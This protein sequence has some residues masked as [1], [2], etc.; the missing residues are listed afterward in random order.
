MQMTL[1]TATAAHDFHAHRGAGAGERPADPL[2]RRA[3]VRPPSRGAPRRCIALARLAA[4]QRGLRVYGQGVTTDAA[5]HL[6]VRG[7][8]PLRRRRGVGRGDRRHARGA[9]GEARRSRAPARAL[10]GYESGIVTVPIPDITILECFTPET[11]P[12]REPAPSA[13]SPSATGK[14]PVDAMLDIAVADDLRTVFYAEPANVDR[15]ALREIIDYAVD[16]PRRVRRR[17]AHEV[18][19][20]R[21]LSDRVPL[22]RSC[23]RRRCAR[24]STR[25]GGSRRCPRTAPASAT[26]ARSS[27]ARPPTSSSTTSRSSSACRPRSRTTSRAASGGASSARAATAASW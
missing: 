5:L 26:A 21:P 25:T 1:A 14:H 24:S 18:L 6:H 2:Q 12:L 23:A 27:R 15:E 13:R 4:A 16:P 11:K 3:V 22:A 9:Q 10:R 7:L 8:E 19:H 17:R 20:R